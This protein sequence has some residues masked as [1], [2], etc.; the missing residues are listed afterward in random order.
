MNLAPNNG[1]LYLGAGELWADFWVNGAAT[2]AFVHLG[3]VDEFTTTGTPEFKD[4]PNA[5]DGLRVTY[6]QVLTGLKI[7]YGMKLRE[8]TAKTLAQNLLGTAGVFTQTANPSAT[9]QTLAG[10]ASQVVAVGNWYDIGSKGVTGFSCKQGATSLVAGSSPQDTTSGKDYYLDSEQGL[11]YIL[12]Q[13]TI[14]A[15]S[16]FTWAGAIPGILATANKALITAASISSAPFATFRF[17]SAA[18]QQSGPRFIVTLQQ[19]MAAPDGAME[20]IKDD[21]SDLGFKGQLMK[22][23]GMPTGQEYMVAQEL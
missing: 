17:R 4:I 23:A 8:L 11:I 12:P 21:F 15:G 10:G 20:W 18:N 22:R 14:A 7:E 13:S 6:K 5:M 1:N 19:A 2:G 9:N 3:L 16:V